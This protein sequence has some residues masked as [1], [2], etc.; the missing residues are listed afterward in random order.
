MTTELVQFGV[1]MIVIMLGF[2]VSFFALL[3]G[4]NGITFQDA[5]LS[6]F[7]AMLGEIG[8]FEEF[9]GSRYETVA[10]L[11]LVFYLVVMTIMLLNL[12]V[13]VL[14]TA[15]SNMEQNVLI[16]VSKARLFMY[17]RWVVASDTLPPPFNL[18]QMAVSLPLKLVDICVVGGGF[19][20]GAKRLVGRILFWL[21]MGPLAV[22]GG[23]LLWLISLPQALI[24]VNNMSNVARSMLRLQRFARSIVCVF[25]G[26]LGVPLCL[27]ISWITQVA[28]VISGTTGVLESAHAPRSDETSVESLLKEATGGL[29]MHDVRAYLKDPVTCHRRCS[30]S[31]DDNALPPTLEHMKLLRERLES[32]TKERI[33]DLKSSL[34]ERIVAIIEEKVNVQ[35]RRLEHK[36]DLLLKR[37]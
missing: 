19:H 10:T 15:H 11:L 2:V 20:T 26:L 9:S 18:M 22:L 34:D 16:R 1:V 29:G 37:R 3:N 36:L 33:D 17:Y 32:T 25:W 4:I 6:V 27:C 28:S 8:F 14:S 12:L 31:R 23:S 35:G 5:W 30:L 21:L 13:A 24:V 7:K